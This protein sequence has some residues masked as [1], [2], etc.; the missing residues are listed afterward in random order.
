MDRAKWDA[1][2]KTQLEEYNQY[3]AEGPT[4][5]ARSTWQNPQRLY[6]GDKLFDRTPQS[7]PAFMSVADIM[8][9]LT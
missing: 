8:E 7:T 5:Y 6:G 3:I 1:M 4:A 9:N 2:C